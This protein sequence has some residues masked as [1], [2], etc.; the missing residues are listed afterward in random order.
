MA[1]F[2]I[3]AEHVALSLGYWWTVWVF[4]FSHSRVTRR[5]MAIIILLLMAILYWIAFVMMPFLYLVP[6]SAA[7]TFLLFNRIMPPD[8][9]TLAVALALIVLIALLGVFLLLPAIFAP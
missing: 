3:L 2:S 4:G 5:P 7:I 1:E 9:R 6:I 8:Q